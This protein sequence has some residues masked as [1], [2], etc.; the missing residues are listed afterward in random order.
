[1]RDGRHKMLESPLR[2]AAEPP[3]RRSIRTD[4]TLNSSRIPSWPARRR[5][6]H[7][8]KLF[9]AASCPSGVPRRSSSPARRGG[10]D[11][12]VASSQPAPGAPFPPCLQT[13]T[14]G[15]KSG[16]LRACLLRH[17]G[18]GQ[19]CLTARLDFW[20]AAFD[21][22]ETDSTAAVTTYEE[23]KAKASAR[24]PDPMRQDIALHWKQL[25]GPGH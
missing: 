16:Y 18:G 8:S 9:P 23:V 7:S 21:R 25:V 17:H 20:K 6:L 22:A 3:S 12:S 5:R 13:L 10:D 24:F 4:T 19:T 1:M 14:S 2:I 15:H 11:R